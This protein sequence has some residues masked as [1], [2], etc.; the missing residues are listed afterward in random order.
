MHST[1][2]YVLLEGNDD[3]RFFAR[4]LLPVLADEGYRVKVW[5]Y[6]REK[7]KRTELFVRA[8]RKSGA[9]Y[10]YVRDIDTAPTIATKK[11]EIRSWY[12]HAVSEGRIVI[13]ITEIESWYLAGVSGS[14][15]RRFGISEEIESTD[16]LTK[17]DFNRI[18]PDGMSRIHFMRELLARF[19]T[20]VAMERNESFSY[21]MHRYAPGW[22]ARHQGR[23]KR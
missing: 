6:A 14:V 1:L 7:R 22:V 17:E 9:G 15:L 4:V 8:V 5:K 19:D 3:E 23:L 10:L 12:H 16:S 2:L 18:V 21:F 13:V 11:R 20:G